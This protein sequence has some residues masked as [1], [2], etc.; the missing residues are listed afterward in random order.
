M[1]I[2]TEKFNL[3]LETKKIFKL[4]SEIGEKFNTKI[5]LNN[6]EYQGEA[7]NNTIIFLINLNFIK[8]R[9]SKYSKKNV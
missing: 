7:L 3:F 2:E 4:Y 5:D 6:S 8:Y 9:N 1:N